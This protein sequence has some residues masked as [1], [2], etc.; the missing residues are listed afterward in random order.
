MAL[1]GEGHG[2]GQGMHP[3]RCE[4]GSLRFS[5]PGLDRAGRKGEIAIY[6]IGLIFQSGEM[7]LQMEIG[8]SGPLS[9]SVSGVENNF[10]S[11]KLITRRRREPH[12]EMSLID[13]APRCVGAGRAYREANGKTLKVARITSKVQL[14]VRG[15]GEPDGVQR[16]S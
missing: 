14:Q 15:R 13:S 10:C 5:P 8:R 9:A 1:T 6:Q 2:I 16:V 12:G 11:G 4:A 3:L 7:D